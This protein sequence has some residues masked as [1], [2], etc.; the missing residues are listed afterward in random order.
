MYFSIHRYENGQF[1]PNLR[2]SDW[3]Y[4]GSGDGQ[5]FNINVP[6]NATGMR[7]T[8]YLAIFHKILLPVISEVCNIYNWSLY[9]SNLTKCFT[10]VSTRSYFNIIWL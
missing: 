10:L 7:D 6:L 2:E 4:T 5:G 1:W 8:D 3:D 9:K